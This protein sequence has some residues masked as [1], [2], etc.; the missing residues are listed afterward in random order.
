MD[1]TNYKLRKSLN[2]TL[3]SSQNIFNELKNLHN[4][5]YNTL[6][7]L[8]NDKIDLLNKI[9][10]KSTSEDI[11]KKFEE[12][13]NALD[14]KLS[15]KKDV[16][17]KQ[18]AEKTL[19]LFNSLKDIFFDSDN[20]VLIPD[21]IQKS[22]NVMAQLTFFKGMADTMY[23]I[24]GSKP[25]QTLY[26]NSTAIKMDSIEKCKSSLKVRPPKEYIEELVNFTKA[27]TFFANFLKE[28]IDDYK[29]RK[30]VV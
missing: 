19:E 3:I 24:A 16:N 13:K 20:D 9:D 10:L 15:K 28:N 29:D 25:D 1:D 4:K 6:N 11:A 17:Y 22:S 18:A 12:Y 2:D 27:A 23:K 7:D 14:A 26:L 21:D 5:N 8:K 30:S